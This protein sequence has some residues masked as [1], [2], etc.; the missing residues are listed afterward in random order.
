MRWLFSPITLCVSN[1][2][3]LTLLVGW[4]TGYRFW[5]CSVDNNQGFEC[6]RNSFDCYKWLIFLWTTVVSVKLLHCSILPL[7]LSI[8]SLPKI[9]SNNSF[10]LT[11]GCL[12]KWSTEFRAREPFS[13]SLR[14]LNYGL[15]NCYKIH[16]RLLSSKQL[17][18]FLLNVLALEKRAVWPICKI[19]TGYGIWF[20]KTD[21][22]CI[23]VRKENIF[24]KMLL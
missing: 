15:Q 10:F 3:I 19:I 5:D 20:Q 2:E 12:Y 21:M 17:E 16:V 4:L 23:S 7:L 6:I 8:L 24:S 22:A 14:L 1:S 13:W 11:C 18:I 9:S